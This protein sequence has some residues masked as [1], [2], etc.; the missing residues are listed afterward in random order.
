M[1][2]KLL[3]RVR[4]LARGAVSRCRSRLFLDVH[5]PVLSEEA[6]VSFLSRRQVIRGK[7]RP[8]GGAGGT[9]ERAHEA[10]LEFRERLASR[11]FVDPAALGELRLGA[12]RSHP[13]WRRR[14]L[15]QVSQ[16]EAGLRI[17][18]TAGPG[19]TKDFPWASVPDGP[20]G[21]SLYPFRPH[22]FGFLPRLA[23]AALDQPDVLGRL[24]DVVDGWLAEAAGGRNRLCYGTNLVV[25]QRVLATSWAWAFLASR[26]PVFSPEGL[27]LET[28]LLRI[29]WADARFLEPR[30][31]GSVPNNHLL[32]DRFAGWFLTVVVPEFVERVDSAAEASFRDELL[33]QTYEDGGSFEHSA[34]YHEFACEMGAAYLLLCRRQGRR[35]DPQLEARVEALLRFQAALTGPAAVPLPFGN[36]VEDTFFPLDGGEGWCPGSLRELYRA[37]FHTDL[38]PAPADDP[39]V[40]RAFWLLGGALAP[41]PIGRRADPSPASFPAAGVHVYHDP[42]LGGRLAFRTG[43]GEGC[44]VTAGHMHAD[45]LSVYLSLGGQPLVVDAGTHT[46]RWPS[47]RWPPG[48][49]RWRPYL[50][51]PAAHNAL[52]IAGEDPLGEILGSFRHANTSCRVR[53]RHRADPGLSW[54]EAQLLNAGPYTGYTRGCIHVA[55]TYWVVYDRPPS[56]GPNDKARWYG[57]Q[58]APGTHV[59]SGEKVSVAQRADKATALSLLSTLPGPPQLLVGSA[60]PLGGWVSPRYGEIVPAPQLRYPLARDGGP[61]AFVLVP[62][63]GKRVLSS[64]ILEPL[65][66]EAF[67]LRLTT[68]DGEDLLLVDGSPEPG[69]PVS[70]AGLT[71]EGRVLWMRTAK[72]YPLVWRW[73]DGRRLEWPEHQMMRVRR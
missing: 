52:T 58:F 47:E 43:P 10:A 66:A 60:E 14:L 44:P 59:T 24:S 54:S 17:Y 61:S 6:F 7:V 12:Y 65:S 57:F 68:D 64:A 37:L 70:L 18:T 9:A 34:H 31:G 46:Y 29:L 22:R 73:L 33:R 2:R 5:R 21:D 49:P 20:G 27:G 72:G 48:T 8:G 11:W 19:L 23:L 50:A 51:G 67:A 42:E 40:E 4:R 3:S 71:F 30:L 36:A 63:A 53:C 45:L 38:L 69:R 41:S 39:T 35:P 32:A 15:E 56:P 62:S 26:A 1:T 16:D 25:L 13:E 55:G 28:R